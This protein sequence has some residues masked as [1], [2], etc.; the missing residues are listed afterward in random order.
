MTG[1]NEQNNEKACGDTKCNTDDSKYNYT[2]V[3]N[4]YSVRFGAFIY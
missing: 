2:T 3:R 4:D 1:K